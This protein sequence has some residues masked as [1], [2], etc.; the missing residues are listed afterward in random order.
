MPG[1]SGVGSMEPP[2]SVSVDV[3][4]A[5]GNVAPVRVIE[6]SWRLLLQLVPVTTHSRL[7]FSAVLLPAPS[8]A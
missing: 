4:A 1:A 6:A 8:A 2:A 5:T 7:I 3:S